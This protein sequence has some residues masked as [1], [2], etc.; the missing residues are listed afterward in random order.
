MPLGV[1]E[2]ALLPEQPAVLVLAQGEHRVLMAA[3]VLLIPAAG[4]AG[5]ALII[6]AVGR[7]VAVC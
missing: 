3:A 2:V 5:A 6:L 4:A 1:E 7:V